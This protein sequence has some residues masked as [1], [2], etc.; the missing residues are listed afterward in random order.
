MVAGGAQFSLGSFGPR[1]RAPLAHEERIRI[2]M[3]QLLQAAFSLAIEGAA[4]K[5]GILYIFGN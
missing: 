2:E 5:M 3:T 4:E 1:E